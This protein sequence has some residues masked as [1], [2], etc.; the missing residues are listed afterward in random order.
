MG[1]RIQEVYHGGREGKHGEIK[2]F[3]SASTQGTFIIRV[4]QSPTKSIIS[5]TPYGYDGRNG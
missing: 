1:L 4:M 3:I 5:S 2:A